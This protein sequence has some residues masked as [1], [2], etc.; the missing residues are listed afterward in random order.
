[1]NYFAY[2]LANDFIPSSWG[3]YAPTIID[4]V[5]FIG[6]FGLFSVLFLLF[7]RFM[8][9]IAASEIKALSLPEADPHNREHPHNRGSRVPADH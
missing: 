3:Y 6:T 1:M 4:I 2:P 5:T 7:L 8:P 9:M